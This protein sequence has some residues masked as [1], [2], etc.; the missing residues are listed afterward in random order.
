MWGGCVDTGLGHWNFS[1]SPV[2]RPTYTTMKKP[3]F[4][5]TIL[6]EVA[7]GGR[8]YC[9]G[10]IVLVNIEIFRELVA[11][12]AADPKDRPGAIPGN[13]P[14]GAAIDVMLCGHACN[15]PSPNTH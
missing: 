2:L 12:F 5:T 9:P 15:L 3:E 1:C 6:R 4:P 11:I 7:I 10:D 8:C 14:R 13:Q